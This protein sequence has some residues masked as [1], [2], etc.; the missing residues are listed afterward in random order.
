MQHIPRLGHRTTAADLSRV[1]LASGYDST[2]L[3]HHKASNKRA[4]EE[5]ESA[6]ALESRRGLRR[7]TPLTRDTT[8]LRTGEQHPGPCKYHNEPKEW[9]IHGA[10]ESDARHLLTRG[11]GLPAMRGHP[12]QHMPPGHGGTE[13]STDMVIVCAT[14]DLSTTTTNGFRTY[15]TRTLGVPATALAYTKKLTPTQHQG[16]GTAWKIVFKTTQQ[17]AYV[18]EAGGHTLRQDRPPLRGRHV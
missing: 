12:M 16:Q 8:S 2:R 5:L 18:L 7:R 17:C 3:E 14:H 4:S 11:R 15:T 6:R 10:T 13:P 9:W 1:L